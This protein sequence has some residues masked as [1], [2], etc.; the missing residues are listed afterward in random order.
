MRSHHCLSSTQLQELITLDLGG[1]SPSSEVNEIE[2]LV[3]CSINWE[4]ELVYITYFL[5]HILEA[6]LKLGTSH[7]AILAQVD[8]LYGLREAMWLSIQEMDVEFVRF[9]FRRVRDRRESLETCLIITQTR[10][11]EREYG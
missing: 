2:Y 6:N 3:Q 8:K 4:V 7:A 10:L 9:L 11:S 1:F 5:S